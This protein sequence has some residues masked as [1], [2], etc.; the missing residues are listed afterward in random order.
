MGHFDYEM[1]A[2][3]KCDRRTGPDKYDTTGGPRYHTRLAIADTTGSWLPSQWTSKGVVIE[4]VARSVMMQ[5]GRQGN[6]SNKRKGR[7]FARIGL[8]KYASGPL[9]N[10]QRLQG[11]PTGGVPR[12][13]LGQRI[14][15]RVD[16][17]SDL[18]LNSPLKL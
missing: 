8:P 15:G 12:L 10:R 13:L 6:D 4:G 3:S 2:S 7:H 17:H 9:F 1:C 5:Q 18:Q 16:I 14:V 11:I